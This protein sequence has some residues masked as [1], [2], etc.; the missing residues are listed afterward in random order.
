[1]LDR[2]NIPYVH[3]QLARDPDGRAI[4]GGVAVELDDL[5][6]EIRQCILTPKRSVPLNPE[7]GCDLDQYRDR[8]L[9]TRHLFV[10]AEVRE[11]LKR[12]VPRIVVREVKVAAEFTSVRIQITW[13]P[14]EMVMQEFIT[15]EVAY[16]F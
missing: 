16:V 13:S 7:K 3:W 11:A 1:M 4:L 15:T 6:Q 10:A 2:N 14:T 12:D 8:P 5:R 9:N